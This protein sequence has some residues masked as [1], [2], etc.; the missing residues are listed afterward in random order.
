MSPRVVPA[1]MA[2]SAPATSDATQCGTA[3]ERDTVAVAGAVVDGD[4]DDPSD[5][6]G[7]PV[8]VAVGGGVG[9]AEPGM[10]T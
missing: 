9:V 3:G 2:G 6:D 5:G 1:K 8:A 4:A 7:V 10:R